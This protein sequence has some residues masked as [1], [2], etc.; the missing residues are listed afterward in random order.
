M[1][2]EYHMDLCWERLGIFIEFCEMLYVIYPETGEL[3]FIG[4]IEW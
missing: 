1:S 4:Y 3:E 2:N